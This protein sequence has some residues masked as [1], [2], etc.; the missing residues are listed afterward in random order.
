MHNFE[1]AI[2]RISVFDGTDNFTIGS[3]ARCNPFFHG[4]VAGK[5]GQIEVTSAAKLAN[6]CRYATNIIEILNMQ[7]TCRSN[8]NDIGVSADARSQSSIVTGSLL[9]ER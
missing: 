3:R 4:S 6:N 1:S 9:R 5:G 2:G 8:A 7:R